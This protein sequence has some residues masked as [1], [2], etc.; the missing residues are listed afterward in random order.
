[1]YTLSKHLG[2]GEHPA[3]Q[4]RA[5][6]LLQTAS[7]LVANQEH[8]SYQIEQVN[9]ADVQKTRGIISHANNYDKTYHE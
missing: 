2:R 5:F 7:R 3:T 9:E 1:M 6:S 4:R 8:K